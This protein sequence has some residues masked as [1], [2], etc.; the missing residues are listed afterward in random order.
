MPFGFSNAPAGFNPFRR[1]SAGAPTGTPATIS[2]GLD[3]YIRTA[4]SPQAQ[5]VRGVPPVPLYD[6]NSPITIQQIY[7]PQLMQERVNQMRAQNE[8][9]A[10]NESRQIA[11]KVAASGYGTNS[12]LALALQN[13]L[14]GR[15]MAMNAQLENDLR[16][17][18]AAEN[19]KHLLATESASA[20][21]SKNNL[22]QW[23]DFYLKN[24][25]LDLERQQM[26]LANDPKHV[27]ALAATARAAG[28]NTG[29]GM[30]LNSGPYYGAPFSP[31]RYNT[32]MTGQR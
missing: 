2:G 4:L 26:R 30:V 31:P 14:Q 6:P 28:T 21:L 8:A 3:Q 9:S 12:P 32:T 24:A 18:A 20:D 22:A 27:A 17:N 1:L 15:T 29:P 16:F 23:L 10:G 11:N 13:S 25:Q 5:G 7:G 19:A